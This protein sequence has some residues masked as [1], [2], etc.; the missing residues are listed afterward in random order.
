VYRDEDTDLSG[1]IFYNAKLR[2]F[3][4]VDF[5]HASTNDVYFL[6]RCTFDPKNFRRR[7][8]KSVTR[9]NERDPGYLAGRREIFLID[10]IQSTR[11]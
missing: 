7:C 11:R 1:V 3:R 10:S 5:T 9:N 6:G 8:I 4:E 2:D